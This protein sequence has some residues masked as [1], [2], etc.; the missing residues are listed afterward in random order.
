M[1]KGIWD[2]KYNLRGSDFDRFSEIKPSAV[3]DLFQDIAGVHA[4]EL[5]IGF[6]S[7]LEKKLLWVVMKVK[8]QVI[9]RPEI[10]QSVIVRTWP[11]EPHRIDFEREYLILSEDNEVLIKGISQWAVINSETRKLAKADDLYVNIDGFC[12]KSNFDEKLKRLPII[13][14]GEST[15]KV[16]SAFSELDTNG[17]VNNIK[18]ADYVVN[19]VS[20]DSPLNIEELQMDFHKE[21][22]CGETTDI[23]IQEDNG[24]I[25]AKGVQGDNVMFTCRIDKK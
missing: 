14:N 16:N 20:P 9:K 4:T 15:Y 23:F 10:Y 17:H 2:K 22:M 6:Q 1:V 24:Q 12:E 11:K 18:Y 21:I 8:Y 25:L 7:M 13:E 3:L 5:G 19:A